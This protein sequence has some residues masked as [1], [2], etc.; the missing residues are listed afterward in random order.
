M[1]PT[2]QE[3]LAATAAGDGEAFAMFWRRHTSTVMAFGIHHCASSEDVADLVA[4]TFLAAFRAAGRYRAQA[5]TATPWLL[6]I[7]TRLTS[8]QHR[9]LARWRRGNQRVAGERPRFTGEE[10][11]AVETAID[12]AR[13]A[14]HVQAALR[15]M[16]VGERKVLEL[17]AYGQLRPSEAAVALGISPNA[18]RLRLARA[19]RRLRELLLSADPLAGLAAPDTEV[20][21][22]D[23]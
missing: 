17:V 16:P 5:A 11:E 9:A 7:A 12:A 2:D 21:S 14:P 4:D 10:Y 23:H 8:N 19:R 18:A 6:G 3:L 1:E 20:S 13:Q 22:H 15:A